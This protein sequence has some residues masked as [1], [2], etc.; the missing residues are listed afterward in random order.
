MDGEIIVI[1]L[2][3]IIPGAV[4]VG[5]AV[6]MALV[7]GPR[8]K[9][10]ATLSSVTVDGDIAGGAATVMNVTGALTIL[11]G[12]VLTWR[13]YAFGSLFNSGWGWSVGVGLVL[14]I[15]AMGTTGAL[16]STLRRLY[17]A[18][19]GSSEM[20]NISGDNDSL[21]SRVALI[22]YVNAILVV[23][24]VGAMAAARFV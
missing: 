1:R 8:L 5:A 13:M 6:L 9:T 20:S 16:T 21:A 2:L 18:T 23:V 19:S 17:R 3:H 10:A 15:L 7:I 14:A 22:A 24:A 11:F 12:L 4:W